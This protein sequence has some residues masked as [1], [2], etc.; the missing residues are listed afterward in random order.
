VFEGS[1]ADLVKELA[2][3]EMIKDNKV[4][5][6]K[7]FLEKLNEI[8][9]KKI[10]G[11]EASYREKYDGKTKDELLKLLIENKD[12]KDPV[13]ENK[14]DEEEEIDS[15]SDEKTGEGDDRE[16]DEEGERQKKRK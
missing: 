16:T 6:E 12:S 1:W 15:S 14:E 11:L 5:T 10:D 2:I 9:S 4:V 3:G 8:R 7:D 13:K